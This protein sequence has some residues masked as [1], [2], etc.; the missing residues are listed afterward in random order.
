MAHP[1]ITA[2]PRLIAAVGLTGALLLPAAPVVALGGVEGPSAATDPVC[3]TVAG[4]EEVCTLVEDATQGVVGAT[5]PV[6]DSVVDAAAPVVQVLPAPAADVVDTVVG[7]A[8]GD[9]G[10]QAPPATPQGSGSGSGSGSSGQPATSGADGDTKVE[11]AGKG[12][13]EVMEPQAPAA[14]GRVAGG[15]TIQP[16]DVSAVGRN[17]PGIRSQNGVTLQPFDMP[18]V[19]VPMAFEAP[20]IAGVP[21]TTSSPVSALAMEAV[22]FAG[23]AVLPQTTGAAGWV[24]ATGLGML[25]GAGVLVRRRAAALTVTT[26]DV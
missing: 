6:L 16:L 2:H 4:L 11:A 21:V 9:T 25:A 26:L 12:P 22:S 18:L 1:F 8:S 17:I 13:V 14:D 23:D 10:E 3:D 15:P 7:G 5:A 19:S 24:T 20:Q